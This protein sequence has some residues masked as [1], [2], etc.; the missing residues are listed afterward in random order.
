M[1]SLF[2]RDDLAVI[3]IETGDLVELS[4][5]EARHA[6]TVNRMRVGEHTTIGD[7][8]GLMVRGVVVKAEAKQLEI[9]VESSEWH[10]E[11]TPRLVLVQALAKGDRDEL[12]IQAATELGVSA[13][14]PWQAERSVSRWSGP[15]VAKGVERWTT[16]VREAAKQSIRPWV[17]VVD[18]PVDTKALI[19]RAAGSE[20]PTRT[21]VLEPTATD[22]L[23]SVDLASGADTTLLVV[24]P[25][26]GISPR[27][28]ELLTEA[29][30]QLVRLGDEVLRTSTAGPAA[31]AVANVALGR[32]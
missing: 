25:E 31:L 23:S 10:E 14:V 27:E 20:V 18:D 32:W 28:L 5:D 1:S 12:A 19:A 3:P 29:G 11:L 15:K 9:A 7:G 6:V 21:L 16:I 2:L 30:A 8:R 24:G 4:G 26:G 22:R 17:P 13:I